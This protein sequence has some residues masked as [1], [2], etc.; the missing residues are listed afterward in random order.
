MKIGIIADIHGNL[1]AFEAVLEGM[2][3]CGRGGRVSLL[4]ELL[5]K[6]W[7]PEEAHVKAIGI[8]GKSFYVDYSKYM[9]ALIRLLETGNGKL[10]KLQAASWEC[11]ASRGGH[12]R[13]WA[14]L[15]P[16][17]CG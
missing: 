1:P 8:A 9:E 4:V 12:P 13:L 11:P 5:E 2:E 15:F 6:E 3:A 17:A 10:I 16:G 14:I 7:L